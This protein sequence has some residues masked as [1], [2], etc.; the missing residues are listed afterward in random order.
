MNDIHLPPAVSVIVPVYNTEHYLE[1]CLESLLGQTLRNIEVICVDNGSIDGSVAIIESYAKQDPRVR[2]LSSPGCAGDAR[3]LGLVTAQGKYLFFADSD[4]FFEPDML[5]I[6]YTAAID[7]EADIVLFA[8]R[9]YDSKKRLLSDNVEFLNKAHL[10]GKAVFSYKDAPDMIF[11]LTNPAPWTKLFKRSFIVDANLR[12]QSLENTNDWYFTYA[13]L[14]AAS[15]IKAIDRDFVRYRT[16]IGSSIQ[17][18][19][20]DHPLCCFKAIYALYERLRENDTLKTVRRS[21]DWRALSLLQYIVTNTDN[22]NARLTVIREMGSERFENLHIL[23]KNTEEYLSFHIHETAVALQ[24]MV[25]LRRLLDKQLPET[26]ATPIV[27]NAPQNSNPKISAIVPVHNTESYLADTI[28]SLLLQT[29]ADIEIICIDDGST[30]DSLALLTELAKSDNR[31]KVYA[32]K[33][34]GLSITRNNGMDIARGEFILFIDS[35]DML[36]PNALKMLYEKAHTED[37]EVLLFDAKPF[38]VESGLESIVANYAEYYLRHREYSGITSGSHLIAELQ[39]NNDYLPSAC[40]YIISRRFLQ[41]NLLRFQEGILHEDNAFTFEA[42][43]Q[44]KRASHVKRPLYLR[45]IR[46]DSITR[47]KLKFSHVA[48]Y[49]ISYQHMTDLLRSCAVDATIEESV[50]LQAVAA[51]CISNAALEYSKIT[52]SQRYV[53]LALANADLNLFYGLIDTQVFRDLLNGYDHYQSRS[54]ALQSE[55]NDLQNS[56][57]YRA[58]FLVTK[59]MRKLYRTIRGD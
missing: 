19:K 18:K 17:D 49:F 41:D 38:A 5:E 23:G 52:E 28:S 10:P 56:F 33:N 29:L 47:Q 55:I 21:F 8:G 36:E 31:I 53:R 15:R 45:L 37:L 11:Q 4:D 43:L 58:G 24:D 27:V 59:P 54:T 22:E 13:A 1:E 16:N 2:A 40:M 14:A 3:N 9:R 30:D 32:Q 26:K 34:S 12:F 50:Y 7:A 6:A 39:R 42:L 48:G 35:D 46:Q 44:A 25:Y 20:A 51:N 57:S